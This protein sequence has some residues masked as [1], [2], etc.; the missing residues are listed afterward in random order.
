MKTIDCHVYLEG[1]ILPDVN[2]NATQVSNLLAH[3]GIDHG[4]LMSQRA[5]LADPLSGNRI[6]KAMIEQSPGLYGCV[7]THVNRMDA[8]V[9]AMRDMLSNKRFLG[10]LLT[11]TQ[12]ELPLPNLV[13]DELLNSCRR[14]Q[15][16]IFISTP[17]AACVDAAMRLAKTYNSHKFIFLGM[18]GADWRTGIAAAHQSANIFLEISGA[19]DRAKLPAAIEGVGAHR[20]LFGSSLPHLDPAAMMGLIEDCNLRPNDTRRILYD[21]ADKL[22]NLAE[23]EA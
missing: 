16:P 15:K 2:Q 17:N 13:A 6:L 9:Q 23:I 8:S 1:N 4:I 22:F 7:V 21:N 20:L 10:V 11:S 14:F 3:R 12:P 5:G 18:G 19:L